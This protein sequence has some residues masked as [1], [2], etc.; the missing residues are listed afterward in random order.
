MTQPATSTMLRSLL[1]TGRLVSGRRLPQVC[2]W[3]RS[4]DPALSVLPSGCSR[5]PGHSSSSST[6]AAISRDRHG[7]SSGAFLAALVNVHPLGHGRQRVVELRQQLG[8][9][10]WSASPSSIA[11]CTRTTGRS[12][13]NTPPA[14]LR[15]TPLGR[16]AKTC[17][18]LRD[19]ARRRRGEEELR[20]SHAEI[21]RLP[22]TLGATTIG[23]RRPAA[24]PAARRWGRV[25]TLA[26]TQASFR[27][28]TGAA[29]T[30]RLFDRRA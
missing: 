22:S 10:K 29:T 24:G 9:G 13:S 21:E 4:E 23:S 27:R 26:R 8:D 2:Q 25:G 12:G 14:S 19:I 1:R 30:D 16:M 18:I 5:H 11:T 15:V 6:L 17:G 3:P 28:V 20:R 7:R